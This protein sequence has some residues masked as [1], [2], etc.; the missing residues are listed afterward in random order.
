MKHVISTKQLMF[1]ASSFIMASSLLTRTSYTYTKNE[2]W[3][4][5]VIGAI[6]SI[7]IVSIYGRL[8][9]SYPGS[10]L[11]EINDIVF[12]KVG[13]R[14]MSAIYVYYFFSLVVL[15]TNDFGSF[16][17]GY[18]LASTPLTIT[19]VLFLFL[20]L[21][22][23]RK[24]AV[25]MTRY[26]ALLSFVYIA[27]IVINTTLLTNKMHPSNLTPVFTLS[28]K[29]YLLGAHFTA[30][31]PYCE[32]MA[33]MMFAP[34]LQKP[35]ELGKA[36]LRGLIIAFFVLLVIIVRDIVVIGN[37]IMYTS[38]PTYSSIRLIDVGDFLT[39]LDIIFAVMLVTM[40]F[41][42]VSILLF[43]TVKSLGHVCKVENDGIFLLVITAL[44]VIYSGVF[45]RS[46]FEHAKWF[47][48]AAVYNTFFLVVLP[49]VT[50]IVSE[51]R[52]RAQKSAPD[53]ELKL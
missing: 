48:T 46:G 47:R 2:T 9:K 38:M 51:I 39:R 30:M 43:S 28:V 20:C 4:P 25:S 6:V 5:V 22:A 33:F 29:N 49:S 7:G 31:L 1:S 3:I 17:K 18:I 19:Y 16:V 32:I 27:A 8:A 50:L 42:K 10:S 12:G 44:C 23:A 11:V 35:G 40:T 15:N 21:Y 13:G 37:Y 14:V 45:F 41:F 52:L 36:L 53:A 34:Y 26:A 24:G